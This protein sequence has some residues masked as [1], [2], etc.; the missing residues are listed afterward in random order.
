MSNTSGNPAVFPLTNRLPTQEEFES[1]RNAFSGGDVQP[2][3][4]AFVDSIAS[5]AAATSSLAGLCSTGEWTGETLQDAVSDFWCNRLLAGTLEQAFQQTEGPS[6]FA[7]YLE[8][9]LR[10]MLI[11]AKR[12][13]GTPR[14]RARIQKILT[15]GEFESIASPSDRAEEVWGLDTDGWSEADPYDGDE[16]RLL[17]H[18]H[19]LGL[20]ETLQSSDGRAD[21]VVSN[22][23]LS[24][25]L[26]GLFERVHR[27]LTLNQISTVFRQRFV[28]H[29]PPPMVHDDEVAREISG[30]EAD[31]AEVLDAREIASRVLAGLSDR[32]AVILLER[33]HENRTLEEIAE[34][35]NCS[36]GTADNEVR[37]GNQVVRQYVDADSFP[38]VWKAMLDLSSEGIEVLKA[39]EN[40]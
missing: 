10:N 22:K 34:T 35:H 21:V 30:D 36:R 17:S 7:R 11:D 2:G 20:E 16:P 39:T 26:Q 32:Q 12:A 29:Y 19:S 38:V 25:L 14:L 9:S 24:R 13:T 6:A 40:L 23:E 31:H 4:V 5:A 3:L 8:R 27:P 37:R 15:E 28:A 1:W 33:H 18:L